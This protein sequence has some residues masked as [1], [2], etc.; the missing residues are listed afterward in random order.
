MV[1]YALLLSMNKRRQ[2]VTEVLWRVVGGEFRGAKGTRESQYAEA[3]S[4]Y[5]IAFLA[6]RSDVLERWLQ[7]Y[8]LQPKSWF[9]STY[10]QLPPKPFL[11]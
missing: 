6:D 4:H 3:Y 1:F 8:G 5:L 7:A 10:L 9:A 2:E 11:R